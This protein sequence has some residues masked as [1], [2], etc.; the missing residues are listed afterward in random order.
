M[1]SS[2]Q[3]A[4]LCIK[5]LMVQLLMAITMASV[6][7]TIEVTSPIERV[8][9][10]G[11]LSVHCQVWNLESGHEVSIFRTVNTGTHRIS[12]NGNVPQEV[13]SRIYLAVRQAH[14][15]SKIYFLTI[16]EASKQDEGK[17]E[18]KVINTIG[19]VAQIAVDSIDLKVEY[20]PS[21]SD[22]YQKNIFLVL[23]FILS[24]RN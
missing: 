3:T 2:V 22:F 18:C 19:R 17:Y 23:R 1:L 14:G 20:F 11:I 8:V 12:L 4:I 15:G 21:D 9:E 5:V 24:D 6:E 16:I 13:D 7:T 10:G